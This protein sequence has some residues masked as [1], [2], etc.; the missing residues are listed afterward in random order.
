MNERLSA[1]FQDALPL[2]QGSALWI[3]GDPI[4]QY[5]FLPAHQLKIDS[6]R[7]SL[8]EFVLK[9]LLV[10][11]HLSESLT[12]IGL[13]RSKLSDEPSFNGGKN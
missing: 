5:Q 8:D 12:R 1:I 11:P 10:L 6:F 9:R 13:L 2:G 7:A 3:I 4:H